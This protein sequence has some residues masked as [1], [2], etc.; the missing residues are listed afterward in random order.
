V[1]VPSE[2][3]FKSELD[4]TRRRCQRR[5]LTGSRSSEY[6]RV[7]LTEVGAVEKVEELGSEFGTVVNTSA[8][9]V[10]F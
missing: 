9:A 1:A 5:D 3:Q 8:F 6:V 7:R 10:T 2:D 4:L